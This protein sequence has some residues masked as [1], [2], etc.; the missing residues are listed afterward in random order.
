MKHA[1]IAPINYLH[2]IP[3]E[4]KFHLLLA[5]LLKDEKYCEFY[6]KRQKQGDTI[7]VD[8]GA[9]EFGK[10]L[11]P[12]E[13]YKLVTESGLHPDIVVA[14]DYPFEH[15]TKTYKAAV[16]F[17]EECREYF[18]Y[19]TEIMAVP[20][21]KAGDW[22]GW[23]DGYVALSNIPSISFIGMSILGIP[24]AFKSLTGTDDI[25]F[26][27][28]FATA[29]LQ[30]RGLVSKNV[31]HHYLGCGDPRELL[32]MKAQGV[33]YSNDSSTAF[34]HGIQKT[35]FD[36]SAGGLMLGKSKKE[37]DFHIG[38]DNTVLDIV[39]NNVKWITE[40]IDSV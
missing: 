3:E 36:S 20:Q 32:M 23:I 31:K 40:L 35:A 38:Y 18:D 22:E 37:V 24:N 19:D 17:I 10:P 30:K 39:L 4:S 9:F 26:N 27:R 5:H 1:F 33:A 11:E 15:W 21:S 16:T 7:A 34:W 14:S 2:L 8:N 25:T 28:V 29:Y 13:Y 12:K 6:R